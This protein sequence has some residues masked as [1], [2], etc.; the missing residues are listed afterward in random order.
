MKELHRDGSAKHP[1][2]VNLSDGRI[3]QICASD[4]QVDVIFLIVHHN[5]ELVGPV[6][7]AVSEEQV[8]GC[9]GRRFV[10]AGNESVHET[11]DPGPHLDTQAAAGLLLEAATSA[12]VAV[13]FVSDAPSRTI[14]RVDRMIPA[15]MLQCDF[16]PAR[17]V[18]LTEHRRSADIGYEA[19]PVEIFE[20]PLLENRTTAH[21]VVILDTEEHAPAERTGEPPD[22]DGVHDVSQVQVPCR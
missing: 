17:P 16:V 18:T 12:G 4:C 15:Q 20:N 11:L 13:A 14:A 1:A 7:V 9:V 10:F 3:Q 8:A 19:E 6:A 5:R 22:V 2:Q 21:A